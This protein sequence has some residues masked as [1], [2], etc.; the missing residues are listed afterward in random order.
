MRPFASY[1]TFSAVAPSP[2][3]KAKLD[4]PKLAEHGRVA[5]AK[6]YTFGALLSIFDSYCLLTF[7]FTMTSSSN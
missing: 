1:R 7:R 3:T 5:R 2:D 6:C 4:D